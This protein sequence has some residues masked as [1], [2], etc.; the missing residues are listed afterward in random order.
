MSA[1]ERNDWALKG[2]EIHKLLPILLHLLPLF[3]QLQGGF[4]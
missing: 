2:V 1:E 3:R 4:R